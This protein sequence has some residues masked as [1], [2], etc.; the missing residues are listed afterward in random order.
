M[1]ERTQVTCIL[2]WLAYYFDISVTDDSYV[3]EQ[4]VNGYG[5]IINLRPIMNLRPI[6]KQKVVET[7]IVKQKCMICKDIKKIK[8]I[9]CLLCH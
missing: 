1:M 7:N 9:F 3:D 2:V 4:P 5:I 6:H 8:F